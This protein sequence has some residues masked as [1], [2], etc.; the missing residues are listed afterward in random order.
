MYNQSQSQFSSTQINNMTK[1]RNVPGPNIFL[2][3]TKSRKGITSNEI[4]KMMEQRE[5]EINNS[6]VIERLKELSVYS[7]DELE[8]IE[9]PL[10]G[11]SYPEK[12]IIQINRAHQVCEKEWKEPFK[13]GTQTYPFVIC[14]PP[15]GFNLIHMY[16]LRSLH[17]GCFH[18]NIFYKYCMFVLDENLD[19]AKK[20]V[21]HTLNYDQKEKIINTFWFIYF[22]TDRIPHFI[23]D[24]QQ[25]KKQISDYQKTKKFFM[26]RKTHEGKVIEW[27]SFDLKMFSVDEKPTD[28]Y[29]SEYDHKGMLKKLL[30]NIIYMSPIYFKDESKKEYLS[31]RQI[32][33]HAQK[34][35][36]DE[37][38]FNKKN[39]L[40]KKFV[41]DMNEKLS[42]KN[43]YIGLFSLPLDSLTQFIR[44][45]TS[46]LWN[47]NPN[48]EKSVK[49]LIP[50]DS[51][52]VPHI[53]DGTKISWEKINIIKK[54]NI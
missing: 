17:D 25:T 50:Y 29:D 18:S 2:K 33:C 35:I 20:M 13:G 36:E 48:N 23:A 15:N 30:T 34:F 42:H 32:I 49:K 16:L 12:F 27:D 8:S 37:E 22:G 4:D 44:M 40:F 9:A 53:I 26:Y 7:K 54:L 47:T 10:L 11:E 31:L 3:K 21:Y 39:E 24:E 6:D 52:Y 38:N 19:N 28:F 14:P 1:H 5:Y 41:K 46:F 51:M 45:W 43:D